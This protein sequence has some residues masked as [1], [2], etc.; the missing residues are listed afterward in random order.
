MSDIIIL[1]DG[2]LGNRL[3][4]LVGGLVIASKLNLNPVICWPCNSWC[5]CNYEDLFN[6]KYNVIT[7][8]INDLFLKNKDNIFLIHENQTNLDLKMIPIIEE[9][10]I[11]LKNTQTNIIYYNNSIPKFIPIYESIKVLDS[12]KINNY[13][14]N[15][16]KNFCL[17][18]NINSDTIGIHI[19]RTDANVGIP[20]NQ[21]SNFISSDKRYFVCS[22][23]KETEDYFNKMNNVYV[24]SK[25]SYVQK[26]IDGSWNSMY[27]D[28]EG[29]CMPFN[30]FR[31]KQSIIEGFIDM[32]ILSR[33]TPLITSNSSFLHFSLIYRNIDI[34]DTNN[35]NT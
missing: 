27:T 2:G 1:C 12:I 17:Y 22:D 15:E 8:N 7:D 11:M 13:I 31:S 24:Y 6:I 14:L 21:L 19:R 5:N 34:Y 26:A 32:L 33:S 23:D 35:I 29:R 28:N 9:N 20:N 3:G 4:S 10:I 30:V 18:N 25:T 16:V